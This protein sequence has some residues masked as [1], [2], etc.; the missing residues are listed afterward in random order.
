MGI[1]LSVDIK[2]KLALTGGALSLNREQR[3]GKCMEP[4]R[5]LV[6]VGT[7]GVYHDHVGNGKFM[8]QCSQRLKILRRTFHRIMK[9]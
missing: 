5:V 9:F 6:F 2:E 3:G 1:S 4:L 8:A 7:E